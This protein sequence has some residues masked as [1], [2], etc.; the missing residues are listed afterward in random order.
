M[1]ET[2]ED[3]MKRT[4]TKYSRY[5]SKLDQ[6]LHTV[7]AGGVK[8]HR[9]IPS[10]RTINTVVGSIGD[11]FVDPRRSYCSCSH[12]FFRVLGGRDETCYHLL[13]YKIASEL[14]R[15]DVV[16]F[17]DAEYGQVFATTVGDVFGVLDRSSGSQSL[18]LD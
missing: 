15:L 4:L 7:L 3:R 9:F 11:E 12:F 8:E 10:G 18:R 14:G 16:T 2:D 13:S 17:D 5:G 6:A 1:T